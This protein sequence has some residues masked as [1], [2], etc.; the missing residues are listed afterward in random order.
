[1]D[2]VRCETAIAAGDPRPD[3]ITASRMPSTYRPGWWRPQIAEE[4]EPPACYH[5][6]GLAR[7]RCR[8]CGSRYCPEHAGKNDLC[9]DCAHSSWLGIYVLLGMAIVLGVVIIL[10]GMYSP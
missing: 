10:G 7:R 5:C 8:N 3:R 1:M 2:C 9:A 6:K 4:Y